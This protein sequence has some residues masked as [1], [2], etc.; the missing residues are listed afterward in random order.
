MR[1]LI[2][3]D[4]VELAD[5]LY[6]CLSDYINPKIDIVGVAYNG[7]EAVELITKKEPDIVFLDLIM[8]KLDGLSVLKEVNSLGLKKK[9]CFI[10]IS[11]IGSDAII[12][13]AKKLGA[14]YYLVK[15]FNIDSA[16]SLVERIRETFPSM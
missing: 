11:A 14:E 15:P 9:P 8:P 2:V 7:T 4:H 3:E 6:E 5:I 13:Q 12:K 16:V 10:V 1:L